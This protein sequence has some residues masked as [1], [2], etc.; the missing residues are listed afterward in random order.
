MGLRSGTDL[1]CTFRDY[2][3]PINGNLVRWVLQLQIAVFPMFLDNFNENAE[4]FYLRV[5]SNNY[6][7]GESFIVPGDTRLD[8]AFDDVYD[9]LEGVNNYYEGTEDEDDVND[10]S[11]AYEIERQ[12]DVG[13]DRVALNRLYEEIENEEETNDEEENEQKSLVAYVQ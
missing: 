5:Y 7:R 9:D 6:N 12:D 11:G 1:C 8:E 3:T 10:D 2:F 4:D 13:V